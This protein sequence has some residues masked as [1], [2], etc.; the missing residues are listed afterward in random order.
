MQFILD[1]KSSRRRT[2]SATE[3][4]MWPHFMWPHMGTTPPPLADNRRFLLAL[5][6][7]IFPI[8]ISPSS[9]RLTWPIASCRS[10]I[11]IPSDSKLVVHWKTKMPMVM[12]ES[13]GTRGRII[14][15]QVGRRY[16][17]LL[18]VCCCFLGLSSSTLCRLWCFYSVC[19]CIRRQPIFVCFAPWFLLVSLFGLLLYSVC[20]G[21]INRVKKDYHP[22]RLSHTVLVLLDSSRM[23]GLNKLT[24]PIPTK[25]GNLAALQDLYLCEWAS[26]TAWRK[27]L[28]LFN[29]LT[30]FLFCWIRCI[31]FVV[32][33]TS[34]I[35]HFF[36]VPVH[37]F[38]WCTYV[39]GHAAPNHISCL[40]RPLGT[41]ITTKELG[42]VMRSL[43]QRGKSLAGVTGNLRLNPGGLSQLIS[44]SD[45]Q[46][47]A[48]GS[49]TIDFP[50]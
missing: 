40:F 16:R 7:K 35:V 5:E 32:V 2:F 23:T 44:L 18:S 50:E 39:D 47:N 45:S 37:L 8:P 26:S 41:I 15:A 3:L 4:L 19:C 25:I 46:I 34:W 17:P 9:R 38:I 30:L 24:G 6:T 14:L 43:G 1:L 10:V 49:G 13:I 21:F 11:S 29:C 33:F 36:V 42:T 31:R 20:V 28:I 48:D 12:P 22:V 27:I